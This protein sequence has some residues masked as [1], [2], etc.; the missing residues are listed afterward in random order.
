MG[1]SWV[2]W[3]SRSGDRRTRCGAF[4]L[5]TSYGNVDENVESRSRRAGGV[6][7]RR[8]RMRHRGALSASLCAERVGIGEAG[9]GG[10]RRLSV[11]R[12][13]SSC[14]E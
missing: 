11:E 5:S 6:V 14:T 3:V 2:A 7:M 4:V 12:R 10:M 1:S 8:A 13:G 9:R